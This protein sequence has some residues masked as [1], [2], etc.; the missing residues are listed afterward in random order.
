[1]SSPFRGIHHIS[2]VFFQNLKQNNDIFKQARPKKWECAKTQWHRQ[3]Q[4]VQHQ[5][6]T[7]TT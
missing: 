6:P 3:Q 5:Q 2:G 1:M 7:L 4:E